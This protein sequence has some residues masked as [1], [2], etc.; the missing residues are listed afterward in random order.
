MPSGVRYEPQRYTYLRSDGRDVARLTDD[1]FTIETLYFDPK[2]PT[3]ART[4]Y[5]KS[6]LKPDD[7]L[8]AV[9]VQEG[10]AWPDFD[11]DIRAEMDGRLGVPCDPGLDHRHLPGPLGALYRA[12]VADRLLIKRYLRWSQTRGQLPYFPDWEDDDD[13]L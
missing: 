12:P 11:R 3:L 1:G 10:M 8:I 5:A 2:T 6:R 13:L 9:V 4:G 7:P